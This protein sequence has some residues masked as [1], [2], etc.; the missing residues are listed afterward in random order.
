MPFLALAS[1]S[2]VSCQEKVSKREKKEISQS[3]PDRVQTANGE[4]ILPPPYSS[5][6]VRNESKLVD[7]P[8]GETPTAPAGFLVTKFADKLDNP[9]NTYVGPNGDIFVV[10]SNT[11]KGAD[12]ITVFKDKDKN[13]D[14][15]TRE[16][17]K[18]DLYQPYGMLVLNN[19]F[20][21]AN[22]DGLYRYPYQSGQLKL[23]GE[24]E[25]I[26]DLPAGGYNNHWTRNLIANEDGSKIYISVGSASNAGE[27]GMEEEHRRA[28]ILE[29]N[30]DGTGEIMFGSGLRNPVGMSW[31]PITKELWTAVNERDELGDDLVPDYIT[32]V[33]KGGFYG[34]PYSYFGQIEDP[35]LYGKAPEMV[36]KALVPDVSVGSHTAS[37]G[38]TFYNGSTFPEAYRNG[39]FVGQHGSWNREKLAGY[40]VLFIPFTEG[41][42]SGQPQDFLSGFVSDINKSK[43][44]GRPVDVTIL[45]D[46]SL[47]VNDDSGNVLWKIAYTGN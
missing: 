28:G 25:K 9:R 44:Y 30:P 1:I 29:V 10:E 41:K 14:Y 21:I 12:R 4:V 46:G 39:A 3:K 24:G 40:K 18:E 36:E 38:L 31:N 11:K 33:K 47:L 5:E 13:G 37:L 17:F 42:P 20:Y 6:S 2:F 45:P 32:S 27:H 19:H 15:E 26:V 16:I 8:D 7:W 35:R 43:V 23:N 34:W 22:T